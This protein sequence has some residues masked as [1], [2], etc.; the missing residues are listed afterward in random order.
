MNYP[1]IAAQI[2]AAVGGQENLSGHALRDPFA[3]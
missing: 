3:F 1:A 2:I